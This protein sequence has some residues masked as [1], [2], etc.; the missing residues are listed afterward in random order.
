MEEERRGGGGEEGGEE[1]GRRRGGGEEEG[2]GGNT[3]CYSHTCDSRTDTYC[4]R[5]TN[6]TRKATKKGHIDEPALG[7]GRNGTTRQITENAV[8][9]PKLRAQ[10]G[11]HFMDYDVNAEGPPSTNAVHA[12]WVTYWFG[13]ALRD[14]ATGRFLP[15]AT[16]K[17]RHRMLQKVLEGPLG[18]AKL[19]KLVVR[20]Y[21]EHTHE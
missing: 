16:T 19:L 5:E 4:V 6:P 14:A 20:K 12:K 8:G 9:D 11:G 2:R 7:T 18:G 1:E 15:S 17:D 13:G 21:V 10:V 3:R